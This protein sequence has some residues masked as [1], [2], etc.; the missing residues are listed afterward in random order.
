ME[1]YVVQTG[2]TVNS[3]AQKFGVS[4][5]KLISDNGIRIPYQL[6][7]GQTL[8][9]T[10]PEQVYSVKEGDTLASIAEAFD[11]TVMQLL[12]NNPEFATRQYIYPGETIVIS[13]K[14]NKGSALIVGYTYPFI[15]DDILRMTLPYLK[16]LIMFNYR[17]TGDGELIGS[18]ED[19]AVIQTAKLYETAS[20]M[21]LTA[22]SKIGEINIEVVYNILLDQQIQDK[23]IENLLNTLKIKGYT[24][25]TLAFQ[26]INTA[27]QQLYL[28]FLTK[29]SNSLHPEGFSVFITINPGLTYNGN[30][31]TF[32][33][34]NYTD[35]SNA[36]DGILFLSY[37]WGS[38]ERPPIQYSIVTT[39]SFLDYIV[40][41]V[42]LDKIRI[43]LP[44]LGYD[45]QLPYVAG[46]SKANALNFDSVLALASQM[47]AVIQY[48]VNTLSAFFE[49]V[50]I[51]GQQ[52]I[53]WFKDARSIDS[54]IKILQS[55]GIEGI[56]IWNIMY[57]FS[58]MW[59]VINTQ[60][61]IEKL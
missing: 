35:L 21:V 32:E 16:Y 52:H 41:Q 1:I 26:F 50:D 9:I 5:E 58:Q 24:G 31:V 8:V 17:M 29:V 43:G 2:D 20:T 56:G 15:N 36:S 4:I 14:N 6:V 47:N 51:N 19:T 34:I 3:I 11:V 57:Y 13:Y 60:Y 46:Q 42:P 40:S 33:Q 61:Q 54:T 45:W 53:V 18:D 38:L 10:Y 25:V 55:Y 59:L 22:Y 49:Y 48:D 28:N 12:R 23:I 44:T 37:D 30:E 27:N 39:S 7:V